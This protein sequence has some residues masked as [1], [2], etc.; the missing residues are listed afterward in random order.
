MKTTILILLA[1]LMMTGCYKDDTMSNSTNPSGSYSGGSGNS[2]S[3]G[4]SGSSTTS[5]YCGYPTKKGTPCKRLV[6]G[7]TGCCWQH[8]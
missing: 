2:G 1:S 5:H 7:S 8:R 3:S 6:S 4:G